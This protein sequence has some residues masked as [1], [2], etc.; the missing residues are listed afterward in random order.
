MT[1]KS[2][3]TTPRRKRVVLITGGSRGIGR[4][5]AQAFA[6]GEWRVIVTGRDERALARTA[7][8]VKTGKIMTRHCDVRNPESVAA[9]MSAI[10]S[11][12]RRIDVLINN[13]GIAH[14]IATVDQLSLPAWR[15]VIDTN[16]TGLFLVTRAALPLMQRGATIVNNL[17][18]SSKTSFPGMSAYNASKHGAAGFT[19]T[20]REELRPRGVRVISLIP[21]ATD[22]EIW[23]QFWK[24]APRNKM[25]SPDSIAAAVFAAVSLPENA[26]VSELVITPTGG[27]L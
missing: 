2:G 10:K 5:L 25:M 23:N 8:S 9:L 16:L 3:G 15:E 18:I 6:A 21:G 13:A 1:R 12:F 22:T 24:D 14:E 4:A 27:A 20:L 11:Q 7:G 17:S 19:D 26:T